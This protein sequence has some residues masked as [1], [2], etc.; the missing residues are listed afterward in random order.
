MATM[1]TITKHVPAPLCTPLAFYP[2][3]MSGKSLDFPKLEKIHSLNK[4][5]KLNIII[6]E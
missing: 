4:Y 2:T 1:V 6:K 5:G 3:F